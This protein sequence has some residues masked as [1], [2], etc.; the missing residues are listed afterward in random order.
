[1]S[2]SRAGDGLFAG[3]FAH[4][5]VTPLVDDRALLQAMLDFEA[6]LIRAL[7]SRGLAPSDAAAGLATMPAADALDLP[8]LGRSTGEQGTPVPGL[9]AQ[10]R[11]HLPEVTRAHLHRGATSQDVLDTALMLVSARALDALRADLDRAAAACAALASRHGATVLAGRTLLQQALPTSFAL[12]AAG[13][14]DGLTAVR[15]ELAEVRRHGLALQFGGAVGTLA[16]LGAD[17]PAVAAA[18]AAELELPAPALPWHTNRTR[19][20]RLAAALGTALGAMGKIARD[21][22]LL[23][24]TEVAEATEGGGPGR[25]GSSTMPHKRNPVGAVGVLACAGQGPGLVAAVLGAMMGEHERAA[26]AWQAES[27]PLR[28]LLRLSGSAAASLAPTLQG[29]EVD[30]ERMRANLELGG[31]AMMS[32]SIVTALTP[33]YGRERAQSLVGE[34]TR[35]DRDL[36]AAL[37]ENPEIAAALG[38]DGIQAALDPAGYLGAA[39]ALVQRALAGHEALARP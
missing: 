18:L 8:A 9:L 17:G 5:A 37:L 7:V 30:P 31:A 29:L 6:A 12:K 34:A 35:S 22:T 15:A 26:G 23:A 36:A 20:A 16:A 39:A 2:S 27:E 28:A 4:G 13:W 24:Q 38:A 25:G 19:P 10:I 1:M 11:P 14:L 3:V 21:I 32:E 33:T